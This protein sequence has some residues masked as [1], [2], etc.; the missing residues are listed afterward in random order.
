MPCFSDIEMHYVHSID[1]FFSLKLLTR[2]GILLH[3]GMKS[4]MRAQMC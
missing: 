1:N 2:F 3:A 4:H